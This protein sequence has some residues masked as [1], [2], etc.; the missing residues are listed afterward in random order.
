MV[1]PG[2]AES[3][4]TA[5]PDF[6]TGTLFD[7]LP[8]EQSAVCGVYNAG[9]VRNSSAAKMHAKKHMYLHLGIGVYIMPAYRLLLSIF[10]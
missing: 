6:P 2:A 7:P 1:Q 5:S 10:T 9:H 3:L 4:I 8:F